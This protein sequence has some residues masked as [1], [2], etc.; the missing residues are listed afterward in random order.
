MILPIACNF[1]LDIFYMNSE[2]FGRIGLSL[3]LS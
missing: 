3:I 1:D 2:P